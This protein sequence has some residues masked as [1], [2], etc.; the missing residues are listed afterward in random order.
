MIPLVILLLGSYARAAP[1]TLAGSC[2]ALWQVA[3]SLLSSLEVYVAQ[4][5]AANTTF[6]TPFASPAYNEAVPNLA[7]FCRFGAYIHTSNTSKT[8][9]EVWL[10]LQ[11][12]WSGRFAM[13]GNGGDAGGVNYPDMNIPLTKYH[14]AVASTD[15][16]HNGTVG[17]GS[18]A[19][20]GPETQ[21]DFGHRSVHLTAEYSKIIV[22][23]YYGKK[24]NYNYWIGCSSGG[25]QGLKEVQ[26]YPNDFDGVIAGAA[27]QWWTHL[28]GQTY[29]L[30]AIINTLNSSGFL[31][32]ADY[33]MIGELVLSQCDELDGLKD[34]IITNPQK[35]HPVLSSLSCSSL[36]ANQSACLTKAKIETMYGIYANWSSSA[37][38]EFLFPGFEPG[39]EVSPSFSVTGEPFGPGPDFFEYQVL[40]KTTVGTFVANE[41]YLEE[42]LAIADVTDPGQTNAIDGHIAP[43]LKRGKLITYV[44]LADTLIPTGSSLWYYERVRKALGY[45]EDLSDS[46]RLFTVPGMNH[47]SGG[48]SAYNFGGPS[49]APMV[50][51]GTSQ[52]STFDAQHDMVLALIEWTEKGTAPDVLIGSKYVDNNRNLGVQF[53]RKLCPYPSEGY[54]TGGDPNSADSFECQFRA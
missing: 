54:Y 19:I 28:N 18:F 14:F 49:Q 39:A 41:T 4:D 22:E 15:A 31:T 27:A 37:T 21:I 47:C 9:F 25:K 11:S 30:N 44:G 1:T 42:L 2:S 16:G 7:A 45:P 8:Q 12:E 29:R 35:C 48:T 52:S 26:A 24:P 51:N 38:G 34:G 33:A 23:A 50:L 6:S 10:P 17:D 13:V 36:Q 20:N 40:N 53:Q 3:P 46:Y 43:Y 32:P 5:Y